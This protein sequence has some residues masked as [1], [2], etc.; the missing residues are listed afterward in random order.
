MPE[1]N[2][3]E[4]NTSPNGKHTDQDSPN[5]AIQAMAASPAL[6]D[7]NPDN[8]LLRLVLQFVPAFS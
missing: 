5:Q 2:R 7:H 8:A 6:P 4:G 3:R 1:G